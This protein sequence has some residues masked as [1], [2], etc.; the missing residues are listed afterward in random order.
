MSCYQRVPRVSHMVQPCGW[1]NKKLAVFSLV[2]RL[3]PYFA[4]EPFGA[5]VYLKLSHR[6]WNVEPDA[7]S[8]KSF[9]RGGGFWGENVELPLH[10]LSFAQEKGRQESPGSKVGG[11][12]NWEALRNLWGM[13]IW[14][15]VW[16]T[17]YF[18]IQLGKPSCQLTN[19]IIF[20]RGRY[21]TNQ[22]L[23]YI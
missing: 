11:W 19:S 22:I 6:S 14:L 7:W 21:T 18:S 1:V 8:L 3:F 13:H 12:W 2:E 23:Y 10:G 16:N 4:L 9:A 17:F 5:V 20:Q 15:V